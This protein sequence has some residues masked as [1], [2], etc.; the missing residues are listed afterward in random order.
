VLIEANSTWRQAQP[1]QSTT[2]RHSRMPLP[3]R[4]TLGRRATS[5]AR[6]HRLDGSTVSAGPHAGIPSQHAHMHKRVGAA[7]TRPIATLRW[8]GG[9]LPSPLQERR[10]SR[11]RPRLTMTPSVPR[12]DGEGHKGDDDVLLPIVSLL[13]VMPATANWGTECTTAVGQRHT[14]SA[15]WG[16][17]CL[18]GRLDKTA[19][20]PRC[21]ATDENN[22]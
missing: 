13:T 17:Q 21:V 5:D 11:L 6:H 16:R 12:G 14:L 8:L 9:P 15:M 22:G 1:R 4:T 10:R 2:T 3:A 20:S 18:P 19:H 7:A